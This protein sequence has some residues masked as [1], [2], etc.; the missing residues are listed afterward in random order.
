MRQSKED[1]DREL[2]REA[3]C[4]GIEVN[5]IKYNPLTVVDVPPEHK[6]KFKII[7]D[8]GRISYENYGFTP[9]GDTLDKPWQQDIKTRAVRLMS[10]ASRCRKENRNESGWRY[11]IEQRLFERFDIEVACKRCRRRLWRS[12]MEVDPNSSNSRTT[13]LKDRQQQRQR[14]TCNP[15]G[16]IDEYSALDSGLSNLFSFRTEEACLAPDPSISGLTK[17][18]DRIHGLQRTK[19]F[20]LMLQSPYTHG[21]SHQPQRLVEDVVKTTLNPDNGGSPLLFPFLLSEAKREKGAENFGQMEIQTS[22]PIKHALQ[23]QY[24]LLHI[25]GNTMDVPGGPLIWFLA[26]RGEDWRVYAGHVQEK[27]GKPKY[28]INYLWGG[29]I[30]GIDEILQLI[31]IID[32]IVDWARDAF[33]PNILRQLRTLSATNYNDTMTF[34]FDPDVYSLQGEVQPW[35]EG[36]DIDPEELLNVPAADTAS[37]SADEDASDPLCRFKTKNGVVKDGRHIQSRL[38]G[39]IIT[40]DN[41]E[42][43]LQSFEN[44][45]AATRF[46]RSIISLLSRRCV[47]LDDED[48][49]DAIEDQWTGNKRTRPNR[50]DPK[51]KVY[52]QFRISYYINPTW[53]Q[54]RELTYLAATEDARELLIHRAGIRGAVKRSQFSPPACHQADLLSAFHHLRQKSVRNDLV[55]SLLRRTYLISVDSIEKA[56]TVYDVDNDSVAH[57]RERSI[58]NIKQDKDKRSPGVQMQG[59]VHAVYEKYRIGNREPSEPFLRA[60]TRI[61]SEERPLWRGWK[62]GDCLPWDQEHLDKI[63]VYS[64]VPDARYLPDGSRQRYCLYI[65]D[66]Q[67]D[68]LDDFSI[69]SKL[70]WMLFRE[71]LYGTVRKAKVP[72]NSRN[73]QDNRADYWHAMRSEKSQDLLKLSYNHFRQDLFNWIKATTGSEPSD[74]AVESNPLRLWY[75]SSAALDSLKGAK[76]VCTYTGGAT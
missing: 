61:D 14:C 64:D 62:H 45:N 41:L 68:Q 47:A 10:F 42:T 17:R 18:P 21:P 72:R 38:R 67:T 13:S 71:R 56:Y 30:T 32:F 3:K 2:R 6:D 76:R 37:E 31:L 8:L 53:E 15:S 1:Q 4:Q 46:V 54:V 11:D 63:L 49:L 12:E 27:E 60:S 24:D 7:Q 22:F 34:A 74:L 58:V 57:M 26:N 29:S 50:L 51:P 20:E 28:L 73:W 75:I 39:L 44:P 43:V 70:I 33:R 66:G 36:Q 5:S 9:N 23:L 59:I 40:R 35:M 65:V 19:N 52:V 25:P 55:S 16:R 69:A 48:V